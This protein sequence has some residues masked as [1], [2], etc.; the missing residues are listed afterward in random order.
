MRVR[1]NKNDD[2][3]LIFDL[4]HK[5]VDECIHVGAVKH[6]ETVVKDSA[7]IALRHLL[8]DPVFFV[9]HVLNFHPYGYQE[10]IMR[11]NSKRI[12]ACM[13]RQCGKSLTIAAKAIHF[14]AANPKTTTLIVSATLRQSTLMFEKILQFI[15]N[16]VL[17]KSVAYRSKTRIKLSN[18]SWIIALPSGHNGATLRGFKADLII[19]DEAAFIKEEIIAG[20]A[21][22]MLSTTDGY[23]WMLSTPWDKCYTGDTDVMTEQ[24]WKNVKDV[25]YSN[26]VACL[27][28][29]K[30]EFHK[31]NEIMQFKTDELILF[32]SSRIDLAVT[33]NHRMYVRK[34]KGRFGF[35]KA[36]ELVDIKTDLYFKIDFPCQDGE[37]QEYFELPASDWFHIGGRTGKIVNKPRP[38]RRIK[39]DTWL[40]FLGYWLAEGTLFIDKEGKGP[41][42]VSISQKKGSPIVKRCAQICR[43][44]GFHPHLYN[45]PPRVSM[46]KGRPTRSTGERRIMV[47]NKQLVLYLSRIKKKHIPL[48]FKILCKRQLQILI[49]ALL[50]TDGRQVDGGR[51]QI[52]AGVYEPYAD[53]LQELALKLGYSSTK[54]K[55]G[56][57]W[58]VSLSKDKIHKYRTY[59]IP[60]KRIKKK[61]EVYCLTV[62]RG[63]LFV[64]RN[65]RPC[66]SGNSHIFYKAFTNPSWSV[67]HLPSSENPMI[68]KRFLEEQLELVG[69]ER[70]AR[71]YLA[72][73]I[74]DSNAYFPMTLVRSCIN[75][76]IPG[77]KGELFAG[78]D[79]GGKRSYA[80]FVIVRRVDEK[81]YMVY[82]KCEKGKSYADFNV[83]LSDLYKKNNF[84]LL[85]DETGLGNSI[86]EHLR[87][88]QMEVKGLQFTS[89]KKEELLSNLKILMETRKLVLPYD[90][91]MFH[92]L[93]AIEY[94]RNRVGNFIF[95]KRQHA[96]D[97]LAYALA[98]ACLAA[99]EYGVKGVAMIV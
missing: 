11:D 67:Y 16:S 64:R 93:N 17:R 98:L 8:R 53:D 89:R 58:I 2:H 95:E 12:C 69:E 23:C 66:W 76:E 83:G 30:V 59:A 48:E 47:Y 14:A 65:G 97:D 19:L 21:F 15:D 91:E 13:G 36:K 45:Y 9:K 71:E 90:E 40:E 54:W 28:D 6:A 35:Y 63:L 77:M 57:M 62:P 60:I 22:P 49:D 70:Y 44:M 26:K 84:S 72:E 52:F 4:A 37:E 74:D 41:Y 94:K 42:Y 73:F 85:V 1:K 51:L 88:L 79:P 24:G 5:I 96:Y 33:P 61:S 39:M 10:K 7:E 46:I 34:Q 92:S 87:E 55:R 86:I 31:P 18:G 27:I 29:G 50:R 68:S 20:V 78:Y 80:A 56:N 82:K 75:D 81:L 3:Y 38:V 99:R 32:K 25:N 43:D